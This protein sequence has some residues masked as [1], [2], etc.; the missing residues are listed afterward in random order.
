MTKDACCLTRVPRCLVQFNARQPVGACA[1]TEEARQAAQWR[2]QTSQW[3]DG[4]F[5]TTPKTTPAPTT[6]T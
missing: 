1:K 5:P 2:V 3:C 6:A 4:V